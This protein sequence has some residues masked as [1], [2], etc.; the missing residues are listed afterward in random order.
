M[1]FEFIFHPVDALLYTS[2]L[3]LG[4]DGRMQQ[5]YPVICAWM[6]DNFESIHLHTVKQPRCP[7]CEAP[8]LSVGEGNSSLWQSETIADTAKRCYLRLT[9]M[10]QRDG[11]QDNIWTMEQ[12]EPQKVSSG[13]R[14]AFLR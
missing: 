12:L 6:T 9:E 8:K 4:V 10:G 2:K 13:T 7:V 5:C 1:V 11:K 14:N 3:M